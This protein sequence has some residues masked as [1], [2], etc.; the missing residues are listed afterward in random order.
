MRSWL[1]FLAAAALTAMLPH[2]PA[3][4]AAGD[5][6]WATEAVEPADPL[7]PVNRAVFEL[8][9]KLYDNVL[10]PAYRA[11]IDGVPES[12][13]KM[14]RNVFDTARLPFSAVNAAAAGRLELAGSYAKRFAVNA[15]F[16]A[17]GTLEVASEVGLEHQG[18]SASATCSAP[19][20]CQLGPTS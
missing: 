7:E 20:M 16:G 14:I 6:R 19:T 8:N 3:G 1:A 11:Y 17:L 5:D 2:Q 13:R 12:A 18:A 9:L 4:A 15:T 10:E